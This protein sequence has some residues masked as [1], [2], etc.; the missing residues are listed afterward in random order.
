MIWVRRDT[1]RIECK[2]LLD[3]K[4]DEVGIKIYQRIHRINVPIQDKRVDDIRNDVCVPMDC[5]IVP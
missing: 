1:I 3:V 5:N 2:Y 4:N